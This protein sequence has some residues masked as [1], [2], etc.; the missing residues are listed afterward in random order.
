MDACSDIRDEQP[1]HICSRR[2][3]LVECEC[4][5]CEMLDDDP[6]AIEEQEGGETLR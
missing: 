4:V 2:W 6:I 5:R 3:P 1:V